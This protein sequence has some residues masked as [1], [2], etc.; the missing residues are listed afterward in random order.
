MPNAPHVA[1]CRASRAREAIP[2][3]RCERAHEIPTQSCVRVLDPL[4]ARGRR[5]AGTK[6]NAGTLH[7]NPERRALGMAGRRRQ[8]RT[9]PVS[10][11]GFFPA[12]PEC[13]YSAS[14]IFHEH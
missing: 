8:P 4:P 13:G 10:S 14:G 11:R 12:S 5:T 7:G 2:P 1:T 9:H 6:T 3:V